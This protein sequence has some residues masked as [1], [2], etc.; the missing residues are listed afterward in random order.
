MVTSHY[1]SIHHPRC[2]SFT[3]LDQTLENIINVG[4]YTM[5]IAV[6]VSIYSSRRT[7]LKQK[8]KKGKHN[9]YKGAQRKSLLL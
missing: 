1:G 2:C 8:K 6:F 5:D 4:I 9:I 3:M 7:S